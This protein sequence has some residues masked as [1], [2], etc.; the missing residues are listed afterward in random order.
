MTVFA[1]TTH[2]EN[3]DKYYE[4]IRQM[5]LEPG[6]R[7]DDFR[8]IKDETL[9][10]LR[11]GLRSN[12]EEEL[13]RNTSTRPS[14]MAAP[15]PTPTSVWARPSRP[16]PRSTTSGL[17]RRP[18]PPRQRRHRLGRRLPSGFDA[19]V[20]KDFDA[21]RPP[22][23]SNCLQPAKA[24]K[25]RVHILEKDTRSTL[26]SIGFPLDVNPRRPGLARA[27]RSC[28]LTSAS[29]VRRR[30]TSSSASAKCAA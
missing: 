4:T 6:W 17:L 11:I 5:L 13:G 24:K 22:P 28:N 9:N 19:K 30:A 15:T 26:I 3:L 21:T 18:V 16:T 27:P 29:T 8:R 14:T 10:G 25:L 20:A 7:E 1:G 12:N 2:V 23:R